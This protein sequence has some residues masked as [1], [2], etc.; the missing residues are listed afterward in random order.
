MADADPPS[1]RSVRAKADRR[2]ATLAPVV[3]RAE[4]VGVGLGGSLP[5]GMQEK[6]NMKIW[7]LIIDVGN[8]D[9]GQVL[10]V[11]QWYDEGVS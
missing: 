7:V 8:I 9:V 3:S 2:F 1:P 4:K 6:G 11:K 10:L 5:A